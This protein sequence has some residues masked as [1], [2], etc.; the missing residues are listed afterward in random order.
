MTI[1]CLLAIKLP[2]K[3]VIIISGSPESQNW[4]IKLPVESSFTGT[5]Q[6]SDEVYLSENWSESESMDQNLGR[7]VTV[8][9]VNPWAIQDSVTQN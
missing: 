4:N 7:P 1:K 6:S 2:V 3:C 9:T 8:L 5:F